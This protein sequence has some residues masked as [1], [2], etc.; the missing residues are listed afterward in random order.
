MYLILDKYTLQ[1]HCKKQ[2]INDGYNP[3]IRVE[4]MFKSFHTQSVFDYV[5]SE[6][7]REEPSFQKYISHRAD[8]I[9][10]TGKTVDLWK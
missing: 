4:A 2:P 8:A 3:I 1:K 9:R 6:A 7:Y 10:E 5:A